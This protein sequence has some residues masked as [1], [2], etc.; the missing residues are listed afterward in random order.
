[1]ARIIMLLQLDISAL[2][3]DTGAFYKDFFRKLHGV[4]IFR[5]CSIPLD[6]TPFN[7]CPKDIF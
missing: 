6:H 1:M 3:G 4:V 2:M 5:L 7:A